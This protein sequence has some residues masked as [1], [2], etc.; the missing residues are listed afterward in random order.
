MRNRIWNSS[1]HD[2]RIVCLFCLSS[3]NLTVNKLPAHLLST[4]PKAPS[5]TFSVHPI[6]T[7]FPPVSFQFLLSPDETS[8]CSNTFKHN[9]NTV[10]IAQQGQQSRQLGNPQQQQQPRGLV[11]PPNSP[12]STS[13]S[14]TPLTCNRDVCV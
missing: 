8:S 7:N 5:V 4:W 11:T 1:K 10:I 9:A 6:K 12:P 13:P 2:L 3:R 14:P